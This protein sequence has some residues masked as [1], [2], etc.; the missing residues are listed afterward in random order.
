MV[1]R[2]IPERKTLES[3]MVS[4]DGSRLQALGCKVGA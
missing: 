3:C 4:D 1:E 2:D